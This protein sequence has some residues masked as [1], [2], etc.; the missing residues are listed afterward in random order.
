MTYERIDWQNT[1]SVATP[2]NAENLNKM[3]K[4]I[5]DIDN[6]LDALESSVVGQIVNDPTKINNA[7]VNYD[8]D[9]RVTTLN[10][11]LAWTSPV[12][13]IQGGW[14]TDI[15][16]S[17]IP[18]LNLVAIEGYA[19]ANAVA[20]N[21]TVLTLPSGFFPAINRLPV[22]AYNYT[23]SKVL[24]SNFTI[25]LVGVLKIQSSEGINAGDSIRFSL[26]FKSV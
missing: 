23:T 10:N 16:C 21:T 12:P 11:N 25:D 5:D 9:Q 14:V 20:V 19:T 26:L 18:L 7:A 3:D 1:P 6:A 2:I 4:A 15:T 13:V 22:C 8:I 17:K 24:Y